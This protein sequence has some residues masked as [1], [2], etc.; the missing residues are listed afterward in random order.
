MSSAELDGK[1]VP[2]RAPAMA[3]QTIDGET[4]LLNIEGKELLGVN[5]VAARIWALC[6]G[7]HSIDQL[8]ATIAE[9]FE[10]DLPTA[11]ADVRTFLTQLLAAKTIEL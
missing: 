5:E 8:T 3:W 7:A 11:A 4:V 10:I 1:A 2:Q 6:D 9:E